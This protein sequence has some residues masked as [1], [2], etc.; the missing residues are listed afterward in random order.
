MKPFLGHSMTKGDHIVLMALIART[1][2]PLGFPKKAITSEAHLWSL[3]YQ[4]CGMGPTPREGFK[5]AIGRILA[6]LNATAEPGLKRAKKARQP[7]IAR[8]KTTQRDA[9]TKDEFYRS[10][11]WRTLRMQVIKRFGREC[12]CCGATPGQVTP[13]GDPVRICVDHIK[14]LSKRWDLRLVES[15][16]QILCD[17]CNQGKGAWDATDWRPEVVEDDEPFHPIEQQ[18]GER[19]GSE[20]RLLQ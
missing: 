7:R 2:M 3:V 13:G 19:L 16:L 18:L 10:W 9:T 6:A 15:N 11:E 14:P 5:T 20:R 1:C 8:A 17:E 12:Q 4:S